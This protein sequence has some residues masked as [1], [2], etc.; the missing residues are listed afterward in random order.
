ML[1]DMEGAVEVL[2][3]ISVLRGKLPKIS[4]GLP[5]GAQGDMIVSVGAT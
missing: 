4:D 5:Y 2:D 1:Q 3:R